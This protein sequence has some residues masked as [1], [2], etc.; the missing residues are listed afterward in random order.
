MRQDP[1]VFRRLARA[2][3]PAWPPES[4]VLAPWDLVGAQADSV[5]TQSGWWCWRAPLFERH[6]SSHRL[7]RVNQFRPFECGRLELLLQLHRLSALGLELDPRRVQLRI[8]RGREL[9]AGGLH[10][11]KSSLSKPSSGLFFVD[12]VEGSFQ[13]VALG[14]K[15][16]LQVF[17]EILR[18][19][20]E[21]LQPTNLGV[22]FDARS[23]NGRIPLSRGS[24]DI[25]FNEIRNSSS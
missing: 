6:R 20:D 14:L 11:L 19:V 2:L 5:R 10:F 18:P 1:S 8:E 12:G 13:L 16:S 22:G 4:L 25:R 7:K 24:H 23:L 21:I 3:Q 9:F 15:F 17:H